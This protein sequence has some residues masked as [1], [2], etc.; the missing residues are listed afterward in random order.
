MAI[1]PERF[2]KSRD[3]VK[4]PSRYGVTAR[5]AFLKNWPGM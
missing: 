3:T 2:V 4:V 1:E 5:K